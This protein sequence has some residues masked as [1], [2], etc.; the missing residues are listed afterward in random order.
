MLRNE[1]R[2]EAVLE[3]DGR[4]VRLCLTLGALAELEAAL[5]CASIADLGERLAALTAND[6]L[7]VVSALAAG[8]GEPHTPADLARAQIS[9][10]A[11]AE[12]VAHAFALAF[13]DA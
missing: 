9:P 7:L 3:I 11:A 10:R 8:A 1:A 2:G 6:L 12:A 4:P 13:A 5:D